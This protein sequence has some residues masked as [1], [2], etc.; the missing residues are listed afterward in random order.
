LLLSLVNT[1]EAVASNAFLAEEE[2]YHEPPV[3]SRGDET[4]EAQWKIWMTRKFSTASSACSLHGTANIATVKL[5][6]S[7]YH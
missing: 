3:E 5:L 4:D 2:T 7:R 1:V 6:Q